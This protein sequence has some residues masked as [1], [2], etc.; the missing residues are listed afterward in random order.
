MAELRVI[1]EAEGK[2]GLSLGPSPLATPDQA[3][4]VMAVAP[5]GL[6]ALAAEASAGTLELRA[7]LHVSAVMG[8]STAGLG[9]S[10]VMNLIKA[11]GRPLQLAFTEPSAATVPEPEPEPVA[12]APPSAGLTAGSIAELPSA[13]QLQIAALATATADPLAD[14]PAFEPTAS[15]GAYCRYDSITSTLADDTKCCSVT[16]GFVSPGYAREL[17]AMGR[18]MD[19]AGELRPA[20]VGT[21][22][23][24]RTDTAARGDRIAWLQTAT[25]EF[26]LS[27]LLR[28]FNALREVNS[29]AMR[30]QWLLIYRSFLTD[31]LWLQALAGSAPRW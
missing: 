15:D 14:L 17:A 6:A 29:Q 22:P 13:V 31:C 19:A 28:Q 18:R 23:T 1:I 5:G 2:L 3:L 10:A 9:P 24:A 30:K 20:G 16:D 25:E 21:G 8:Q 12:E 7:G 4:K 11:A 26:P 27:I